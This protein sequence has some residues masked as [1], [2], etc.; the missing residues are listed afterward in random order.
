M[1]MRTSGH[2][3]NFINEGD[4]LPNSSDFLKR[5][6]HKIPLMGMCHVELES[7]G[8]YGPM[9]ILERQATFCDFTPCVKKYSFSISNGVPMVD[10]VGERYG[11]W[12]FHTT[13]LDENLDITDAKPL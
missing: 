2:C 5:Q 9:R 12:Y 7:G 13:D 10:T 3:V 6:S 4:F 11:S 1:A 8:Q